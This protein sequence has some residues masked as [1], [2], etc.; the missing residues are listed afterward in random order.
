MCDSIWFIFIAKTTI[1][2]P[3]H[4][5]FISYGYLLSQVQSDFFFFQS[6]FQR[7]TQYWPNYLRFLSSHQ[8]IIR[9]LLSCRNPIKIASVSLAHSLTGNFVLFYGHA[10]LMWRQ[11]INQFLWPWTIISKMINLRQVFLWFSFIFSSFFAYFS[12][13]V[14]W[15]LLATYKTPSN[16]FRRLR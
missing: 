1:K 10:I 9:A 11:Q 4:S 2:I 15:P 5:H 6:Y 13:F 7:I 14:F 3:S 12:F 8:V 16:S